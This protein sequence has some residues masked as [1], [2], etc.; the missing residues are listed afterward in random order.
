MHL[1]RDGGRFWAPMGTERD[2]SYPER[3][4]SSRRSSLSEPFFRFAVVARARYYFID[5][6]IDMWHCRAFPGSEADMN[7]FQGPGDS[8]YSGP[9]GPGT[10]I[11]EGSLLELVIQTAP[12]AII[13]ANQ[14]GAILSFSPA[15]DSIGTANSA[16][17]LSGS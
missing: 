7:S 16:G 1:F 9:G 10:E 11:Y 17:P 5:G 13:T 2:R 12:D 4:K 6:E 8:R 14:E 15:S 3:L